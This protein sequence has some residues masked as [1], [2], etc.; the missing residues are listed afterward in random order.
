[1]RQ[2]LAC[3]DGPRANCNASAWGAMLA[4]CGIDSD[5]TGLGD[6]IAT[7]GD[8][9]EGEAAIAQLQQFYSD[10]GSPAQYQAAVDALVKSYNDAEA[11]W[12]R[13]V[14]FSPVCGEIK[15]IGTQAKQLI[16]QISAATSTP[17]PAAIE[18]PKGAIEKAASNADDLIEKLVI[19]GGLVVVVL[20]VVYIVMANRV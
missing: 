19:G 4:D 9:K 8:C 7:E 2:H 1:M 5:A 15:A 11:S 16:A 13:H 10:A 6:L 20:G 17:A 18:A 14:P 12:S 3:C